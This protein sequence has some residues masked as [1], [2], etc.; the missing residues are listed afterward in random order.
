LLLRVYKFNLK[1]N[2]AGGRGGVSQFTPEVH[3]LITPITLILRREPSWFSWQ[4]LTSG[5]SSAEDPAAS[6]PGHLSTAPAAKPPG[7]AALET[8][9]RSGGGLGECWARDKERDVS[10]SPAPRPN[11][12][13]PVDSKPPSDPG[14]RCGELFNQHSAGEARRF[15]QRSTGGRSDKAHHAPPP[16]PQ[17][18]PRSPGWASGPARLDP[19]HLSAPWSGRAHSSPGRNLNAGGRDRGAAGGPPPP[20]D[21]G[22]GLALDGP[23]AGSGV[24]SRGAEA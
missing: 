20:W 5:L 22:D 7:P 14:Q 19:G 23:S 1:D 24:G 16:P 15:D 9:R 4:Q 3:P 8:H 10:P 21:P 17:P 12:K 6:W 2:C 18:R 11:R 13:R